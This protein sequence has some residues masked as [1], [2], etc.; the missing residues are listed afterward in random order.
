MQTNMKAQAYIFQIKFSTKEVK[1]YKANYITV[2]NILTNKTKAITE[3]TKFSPRR[4][5]RNILSLNK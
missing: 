1:G 5:L 2:I 3:K 4:Q